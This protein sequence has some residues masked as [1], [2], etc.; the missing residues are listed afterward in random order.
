MR[1]RFTSATTAEVQASAAWDWWRS[2]VQH[3]DEVTRAGRLRDMA[4]RLAADAQAI[5]SSDSQ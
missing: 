3:A 2:S 4:Q 1:Q 5:E